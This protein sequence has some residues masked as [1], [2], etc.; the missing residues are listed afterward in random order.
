MAGIGYEIAVSRGD[1]AGREDLRRSGE[2][3]A[4]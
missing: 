4:V 2:A 3:L 1:H